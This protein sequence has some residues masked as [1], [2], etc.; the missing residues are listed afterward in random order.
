MAAQHKTIVDDLLSLVG[1]ALDR[2]AEARSSFESR[3]NDFNDPTHHSDRVSRDE[4]DAAF[5][6]LANARN[7]QEDL[8]A[9][10]TRLESALGLNSAKKASRKKVKRP[11]SNLPS[12]K[13]RKAP[14]RK[15]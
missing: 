11:A 15:K 4:F 6:M 1:T 7:E 14:A 13:K 10:V 8:V 3:S 2:F 12:V 5:A 9:R